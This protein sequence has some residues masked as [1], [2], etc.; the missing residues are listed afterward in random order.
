MTHPL[1]NVSGPRGCRLKIASTNRIQ[2]ISPNASR[3]V[4]DDKWV[5]SVYRDWCK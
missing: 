4:G 2:K 5:V 1:V 3:N